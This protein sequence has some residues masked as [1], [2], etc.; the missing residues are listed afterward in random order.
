MEQIIGSTIKDI[1]FFGGL[2]FTGVQTIDIAISLFVL[3]YIYNKAKYVYAI[4]SKFVFDYVDRKFFIKYEVTNA[5]VNT[6]ILHVL[7]N[8]TYDKNQYEIIFDNRSYDNNKYLIKEKKVND[9]L[10][11]IP[12]EGKYIRIY[13]EGDDIILKVYRKSMKGINY[14][15]F[16]EDFIE[17]CKI[18]YER[19]HNELNTNTKKTDYFEFSNGNWENKNGIPQRRPGTVFG[20]SFKKI[21]QDVQKF[22]EDASFYQT[23]DIPY[24]RGY[25]LYGPWGSG[26]TTIIRTIA[27]ILKYSIY[28]I[29]LSDPNLDD[30]MLSKAFTNVPA[31]SIIVIEDFDSSFLTNSQ[32]I[33]NPNDLLHVQPQKQNIITYSNLLNILDGLSSSYGHILFL[34]TN[35]IDKIQDSLIRPGRIDL[36]EYVGYIETNDITEYFDYFYSNQ[37]KEDKIDS[38]HEINQLATDLLATYSNITMS[39]LQNYFIKFRGN[40]KDSFVNIKRFKED[41]NTKNLSG[42]NITNEVNET[43]IDVKRTDD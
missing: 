5:Q 37:L 31:S 9:T 21:N 18:T 35:H 42:I 40:Y 13:I 28:K 26:K 24:K 11:F 22:V 23:M 43:D 1:P 25:L 30:T 4:V 29:S 38:K 19:E 15:K 16:I 32:K 6:W 34:T 36:V 27:T 2:S 12:F 8:L 10:H 7:N 3:T 20:K 14:E 17:H 33:M 41:N 39:E